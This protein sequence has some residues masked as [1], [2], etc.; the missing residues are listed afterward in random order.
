MAFLQGVA[1]GDGHASLK[2]QTIGLTS[3]ANHRI[4]TEVLNSLGINSSCYD[5]CHVS[6]HQKESILQSNDVCLFRYAKGRK[7]RLEELAEL[8]RETR[9]G[10]HLSTHEVNIIQ[11][12]IEQGLSTGE[13]A[14]NLWTEHRIARRVGSIRARLR[15]MKKKEKPRS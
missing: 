11:G 14:E 6:I 1:D 13:I 7:E 2:T 3:K 15:K 9:F 10:N 4:L 8:L 5:S 12:Y